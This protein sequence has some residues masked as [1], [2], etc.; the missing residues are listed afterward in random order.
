[1]HLLDGHPQLVVDAGESRFFSVFLRESRAR[2]RFAKIDLA[3]QILLRHFLGPVASNPYLT[4]PDLEN[5]RHL[6]HIP[7]SSVRSAFRKRVSRQGSSDKDL[8]PAAILA[9]GEASGQLDSRSRRWVEKTPLNERHGP[10]ILSWWPDAKTIQLVRDPRDNL[11][12]LKKRK[13]RRGR[14]GSFIFMWRRSALL[15]S[16]YQAAYGADRVLGVR[17]E[18]LVLAPRQQIRRIIEFLDIEDHHTLYRPTVAGGLH[19]WEGNSAFCMKFDGI[20]PRSVGRWRTA[21]DPRER[22]ILEGALRT[23]MAMYGYP[24]SAPS[25]FVSSLLALPYRGATAGRTIAW[26]LARNRLGG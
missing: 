8:L 13:H 24:P 4:L 11:C 20:D 25:P 18:D 16:E 7:Y 21:L 19:P 26:N 15:L 1:M 6:T 14:L 12:T 3:E 17:Y 5:N 2:N 22:D 10:L 23:E 9:Y